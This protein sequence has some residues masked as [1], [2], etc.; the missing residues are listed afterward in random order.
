MIIDT[1]CHYNLSPLFEHWQEHWQTAQ[2]HGVV[3][4]IVVGTDMETNRRAVDLSREEKLFWGAVSFHPHEYSHTTV[5]DAPT[6]ISQHAAA[7]QQLLTGNTKLVAIGET[8]L[9]YF[10]LDT[11]KKA[12]MIKIQKMALAMHIEL[13]NYFE[14][15]LIL[16]VRDDQNQEQAY[17]DVLALLQERYAFKRPF[18]L[19]CVS[20]PAQYVQ[21][22]IDL[23]GYIGVA[24]NVT[25]PKAEAIRKLVELVP[26]DRLCVETD[27]PFLPPQKYRGRLCE[28]WMITETA[29]FITDTFGVTQDQLTEN[30]RSLFKLDLVLK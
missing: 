9:D 8:G 25:Y 22:A 7:L 24:A 5:A 17:W 26:T 13:A 18:I 10:R 14:L 21:Q 29:Q 28:P 27:A 4:S 3:G 20:G 15:P 1:H 30:A 19:H 6:V 11:D 23:G 16:H 2:E 12:N